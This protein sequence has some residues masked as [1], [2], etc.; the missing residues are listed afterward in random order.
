M[1]KEKRKKTRVKFKTQA[2]IKTDKSDILAES[3]SENISMKGILVHTKKM[4]PVGTSCDIEI[5]LTGVSSKLSLS[6]KG[7]ITRQ[8][9]QGLGIE[10]K[11]VDIDSYFHLRNIIMYNASNPKELEKETWSLK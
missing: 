6:I 2:V 11:S 9:E 5:I 4:I 10:F 8:D 1:D 7:V 3:R